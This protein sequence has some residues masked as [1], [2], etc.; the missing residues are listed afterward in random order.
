MSSAETPRNILAIAGAIL[1]LLLVVVGGGL[2]GCAAYNS[3]RVWNATTAGRAALA[4]ATQNRQIKTL[5]AK[6]KK[7]SAIYEAEAEVAR[8]RGTAEANDIVMG[9]LGGPEGYLRY[10]QIEAFKETQNQV[11]YVPTEAGIPITE[12]SRRPLLKPAE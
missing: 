12:S 10:L 4:E 9:K 2:G 8:A 7:E 5:E 1:I 3:T 6:A 11:I